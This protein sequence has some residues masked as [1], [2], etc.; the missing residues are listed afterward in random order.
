MVA[1]AILAGKN[2]AL[3][4][5]AVA[6]IGLFAA[7]ALA[8]TSLPVVP[9]DDDRVL[10][11]TAEKSANRLRPPFLA[12]CAPSSIRCAGMTID[13]RIMSAKASTAP[14]GSLSNR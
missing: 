9:G 4:L 1:Q 11:A 7:P 2:M 14:S 3:R 13:L 12:L 10:S 5:A 6:V 8:E